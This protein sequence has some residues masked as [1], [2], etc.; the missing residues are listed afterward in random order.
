M[1]FALFKAFIY[2]RNNLMIDQWSKNDQVISGY[3]REKL[4]RYLYV[5][6]YFDAVLFATFMEIYTVFL[7][8]FNCNF[9]C[10][11]HTMLYAWNIIVAGSAVARAYV[12]FTG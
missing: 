12:L 4:F 2:P 11:L 5:T 7:H 10:S 8:F 9:L 3:I 6:S 1:S